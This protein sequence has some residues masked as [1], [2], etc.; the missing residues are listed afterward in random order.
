MIWWDDASRN[1]LQEVYLYD[2]MQAA[3][4]LLSYENVRFFDFQNEEEIV[5][6]LNRYMD[7]VHF[8]PEVNYAICKAMAAGQNEVTRENLADVFAGTRRLTERYEAEMIPK[9]EQEERFL[10]ADE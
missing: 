4:E 9:L 1:G 6:D 5:T 10:Y 8:D 2:E 3:K 7:T